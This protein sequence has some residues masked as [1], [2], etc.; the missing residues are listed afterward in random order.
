MLLAVLAWIALAHGAVIYGDDTFTAMLNSGGFDVRD[1]PCSTQNSGRPGAPLANVRV[2]ILGSGKVLYNGT[3]KSPPAAADT[4]LANRLDIK[5]VCLY[6][7][8]P[9]SRAAHQ[10]FRQII[11]ATSSSSLGV[12]RFVDAGF[13]KRAILRINSGR[14]GP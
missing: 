7:E 8:G 10:A 1:M 11:T 13:Q 2:A 6:V 5:G 9:M 4:I 14:V 3:E 12:A